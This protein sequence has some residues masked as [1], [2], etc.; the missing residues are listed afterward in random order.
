[1]NIT[2]IKPSRSINDYWS[3]DEEIREIFGANRFLV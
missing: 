1:M 2:R 3:H